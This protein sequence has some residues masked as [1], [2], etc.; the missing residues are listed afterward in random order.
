LR[1][2]KKMTK[3]P[4]ELNMRQMH[5]RKCN[6]IG[7]LADTKM[8]AR[9]IMAAWHEV[10]DIG[11]VLREELYHDVTELERLCGRTILQNHYLIFDP[12]TSTEPAD[13]GVMTPRGGH[14]LWC[15]MDT[16]PKCPRGGI[17]TKLAMHMPDQ[18]LPLLICDMADVGRQGQALLYEHILCDPLERIIFDMAFGENMCPTIQQRH[19]EFELLQFLSGIQGSIIDNIMAMVGIDGN[20]FIPTTIGGAKLYYAMFGCWICCRPIIREIINVLELVC[21]NDKVLMYPTMN[22]CTRCTSCAVEGGLYFK[23]MD[24]LVGITGD[25]ITQY[26]WESDNYLELVE[27]SEIRYDE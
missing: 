19:D 11:A 9:S 17:L 16:C 21:S 2:K 25:P 20:K 15:E 6:D 23:R 22:L 12:M 14:S 18:T 5:K 8:T 7:L 10:R 13:T 26:Y 4:S 1:K 24:M 3:R 27:I